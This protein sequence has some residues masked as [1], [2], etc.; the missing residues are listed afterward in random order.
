M[1][2]LT[3]LV[4]REVVYLATKDLPPSL[5]SRLFLGAGIRVRGQVGNK[6]WKWK[7]RNDLHGLKNKVWKSRA[8]IVFG[9][10]PNQKPEQELTLYSRCLSTRADGIYP[11]KI[12]SW[13]AITVPLLLLSL[14]GYLMLIDS[15]LSAGI[16]LSSS[17]LL[18]F[19]SNSLRH[20][21]MV[22]HYTDKETEL[23]K[24]A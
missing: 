17:F 8:Q 11:P 22:P 9:M 16:V 21:R 5:V 18:L 2:F 10:T 3:F 14:K 15:L 12:S 19:S 20:T 13:H 23:S 1:I 7:F 6:F 24:V 4:K